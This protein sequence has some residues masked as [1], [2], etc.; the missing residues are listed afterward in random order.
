MAPL[1]G[2]RSLIKT[3][4]AGVLV[5]NDTLVGGVFHD[6]TNGEKLIE[7]LIFYQLLYVLVR[8]QDWLIVLGI[9]ERAYERNSVTITF[10]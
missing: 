5:G 1:P 4:L 3:Y 2:D 9:C 7:K 10:L 8:L 6:M